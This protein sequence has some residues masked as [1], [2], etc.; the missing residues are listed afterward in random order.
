MSDPDVSAHHRVVIVG[1]GDAGISVAARLR[2]AGFRDVAVVEPSA[3]HYYQP[4]WTLVGGGLAPMSATRRKESSLIPRGVRWIRAAATDVDPQARTLTTNDGATIGYE[5]LVMAPGI[6]LD[7]DAV[8]GMHEAV[9]SPY[10][11]SNYDAA[12]AAKTWEIMRGLRSGTAVFT[13]PPGAI[14]CPGAPQKIAYLC[15]DHW[16]RE[17][18]LGNIRVVLVMPGGGLFGIPVFAKVLE[19]TVAQY[20][21]EVRYN[22]SVT[23]I[24]AAGRELTL[25]D[26]T[27]GTTETLHYD[28]LH[29]VPPQ[30]PPAWVANSP[31]ADPASPLGYVEVDKH[32]LRHARFPEV[33]ALGDVASTPNSKTGAAVRKQAPVVVAGL[34]KALRGESSQLTY[35][36]YGACPF[37]TSRNRMLLAEF[38]YSQQHTPTIPLIDT[39]KPRYD[40]W[41]LKRYGLP[42]LYWNVL[43]R[44]R[45]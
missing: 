12:L 25:L 33:F 19:E 36:G 38:D 17:G 23:S 27:S 20:G 5:W 2:R 21:I 41:L 31:L 32:T 11:S 1:G 10:A 9:E 16:R 26:S 45:G 37:T 29:T 13:M 34:R 28:A 3:T 4:L 22:T 24:D 18:V 42:W 6:Q 8:P 15:A 44:G 43:L 40:M 39:T 30:R 14:K 7:W 35:Q